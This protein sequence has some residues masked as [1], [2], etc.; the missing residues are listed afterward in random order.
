MNNKDI[1]DFL[2]IEYENIAKAYFNA[3]EITAKWFKY[4]LLMLATPFSIIALTYHNGNTEFDLL[5]LPS[6]I[7]ILIF[8][9]GLLCTFVS[10]IIIN[11]RLDATLYAKAVNGIRKYFVEQENINIEKKQ[12]GRLDEYLVLPT[13]I[14][15][16]PF[17]KIMG[18]LSIL[19]AVMAITNSIYL[20]LGLIQI[21]Q[22]KV[23]LDNYLSFGFSFGII[24][25]LSIIFHL[26]Y[27]IMFSKRKD[28]T[29]TNKGE[30]A[31]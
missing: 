9:I 28:H 21:Q 22:I 6:T 11:S 24:F 26:S 2:L 14:K 7:A 5:K 12:I 23:K 20:G 30:V 18:D 25:L 4:Y 19:V 17:L 1:T 27:Y 31:K 13:D 10:F 16:P 29:Y 3:H 8:L 15:K